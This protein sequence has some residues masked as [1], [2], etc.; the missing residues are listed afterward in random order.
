VPE[1]R[2]F[3]GVRYNPAIVGSIA[4][5]VAAPYDVISPAAQRE[6]EARSPYNVVRLELG[7]ERPTDTPSD[8]RYTRAAALYAAWRSQGIVQSDSPPSCYIYDEDFT[9]GAGRATRRSLIA[10]VR[11]SDW[12]EGIVLPHEHTL[13]RAKADRLSLLSATR[14]QFSPLLATF[15]DPGGVMTGLATYVGKDEPIVEFRLTPGAVAAAAEKHRVWRVTSGELLQELRHALARVTIFIADGHHRYETALNYR[16]LRRGEGAGATAPSEYV[17]ISLV[18]MNDPG[19][20]VLPTHRLIHGLTGLAGA[21]ILERLRKQ[22][23]VT[24]LAWTGDVTTALSTPNDAPA[25][26]T[27]AV[28][29]L[30]P[31]AIHRVRL[32]DDVDLGSVLPDVPGALRDVDTLV[33]QRL[34]FES[35]LGLSPDE[36]EAGERIQYTRDQSEAAR[37]FEAG[38]AQLA[39]FLRATPLDQLRAAARAGQRMPQKTTY[40]YPKPVTGIVFYDHTVAWT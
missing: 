28:I 36:A 26:P 18:E 37:A 30:Q 12:S 32:R 24:R 25:R 8:N 31:G 17:L 2:P 16:N 9:Y 34:I 10:A 33:L 23:T 11:L 29:G 4:D 22:F 14:T 21:D 6:L 40:F 27:F 3:A 38:Q 1:I 5:V 39:F 13:P 35:V 7:A 20:V 19:L 15:D